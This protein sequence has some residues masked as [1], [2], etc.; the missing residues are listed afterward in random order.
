[1]TPA[2]NCHMNR[3]GARRPAPSTPHPRPVRAGFGYNRSSTRS[4]A[5]SHDA[6]AQTKKKIFRRDVISAVLFVGAVHSLVNLLA[7]I[8]HHS[9]GASEHWV[10][11]IA[12]AGYCGY[13]WNL[14]LNRL[15]ARVSLQRG[16]VLMMVLASGILSVGAFQTEIVPYCLVIIAFLLI[17]G[18]VDV[19]YSTLVHHLYDQD[20]R[21]RFLSR[22]QFAIAITTALLAPLFGWLCAGTSGHLPA[23]LLAAVLMAAAAAFFRSLPTRDEHH[24]ERF[25][26]WEVVRTAFGDPRF[27]RVAILLTI[28]GWIGAGS[29]PILV[30]LY[31]R[32]GFEEDQVGL[33][34]AIGTVGMLLGLLLITPHLRFAGGISNFRLCFTSSACAL[35][36]YGIVGLNEPGD[37]SFWILACG[38]FAFGI[39]LVGFSLAMQT[40]G[41]NLAPPGKTTLY[42]N[43]LM[44]VLG[45]RGMFMPILTAEALNLWGLRTTLI[46]SMGVALGCAA[47]VLLPGIDGPANTAEPMG[48]L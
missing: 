40:T 25:R 27:R 20:E 31:N 2:T 35:V 42:V 37:W 43:A 32:L 10:G 41:L 18:L 22:R 34:T 30:L 12:A 17:A 33:L 14:F 29:R 46:I 45:V 39:S 23:F 9:L 19:Q 7:F 24:M 13:L 8:A 16:I 5:L 4:T 36:I 28:Y 38:A 1:M 11:I 26:A 6:V 3:G 21:P 47:V 48:D 44:I 15:T